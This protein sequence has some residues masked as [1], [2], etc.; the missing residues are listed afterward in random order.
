MAVMLP[1]S[2][3]VAC[4][5]S[6][7]PPT[8]S[9]AAALAV[10]VKPRFSKG[11]GSKRAAALDPEEARRKALLLCY[12]LLHKA[13][14]KAKQFEIRELHRRV[15]QAAKAGT[16]ENGARLCARRGWGPQQLGARPCSLQLR[17]LPC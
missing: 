3:M 13:V 5:P 11:S 9:A 7:L 15:A 10:Q 8:P 4:L 16:S 6:L 2:C 1:A 14:K 12:K 17:L